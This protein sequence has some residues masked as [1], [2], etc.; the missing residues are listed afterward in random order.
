MTGDGASI[1]WS[2]T[3]DDDP[4]LRA[5]FHFVV[6]A[7][8][9]IG[10]L[11]VGLAGRVA[12][13]AI[14]TGASDTLFLLGAAVVVLVF[15]GR[16]TLGVLATEGELL[17]DSALRERWLLAVGLGWAAGVV[18]V[19][20]RTTRGLVALGVVVVTSYVVLAVCSTGGRLD[21]E[22]LTVEGRT[23]TFSLAGLSSIRPVP[24]G[25]VVCYLLSFERG[26][27]GSG[28][29]RTL[30]VPC[31]VAR[32]VASV[33]ERAADAD[34]E[35]D[36]HVPGRG[37]RLV[38]AVLGVCLLALGPALWVVLPDDG[39]ATLLIVYLTLFALLVGALCLRYALVQ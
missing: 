15:T 22:T 11:V 3:P 6:G 1:E 23:R 32:D 37:E 27:T 26:T 10:L 38:A 19:A 12:W 35:A 16:A 5:L 14:R 8:V 30:V 4:A 21:P 7:P 29:P 20:P 33:L 31:R 24:L 39:G 36:R 25:P 13:R 2:Y 18:L 28:T 34:A 17:A 9:G